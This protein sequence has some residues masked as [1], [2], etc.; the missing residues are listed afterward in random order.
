MSLPGTAGEC[1]TTI[2]QL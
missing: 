2:K 1:R